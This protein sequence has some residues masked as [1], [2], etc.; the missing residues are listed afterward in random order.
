MI[1][2][3]IDVLTTIP[4][5]ISVYKD[6]VKRRLKRDGCIVPLS[7]SS[8]FSSTPVS[9]GHSRGRS[10]HVLWWPLG[11]HPWWYR[12]IKRALHRFNKDV[13][14]S[15]LLGMAIPRTREKPVSVKVAWKNF[16]PK[17]QSLLQR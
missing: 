8:S 17:T 15:S 1:L 11:H 3:R 16:L 12:L 10:V 6:E 14:M 4:E 7:S 9:R 2:N 5:A 13:S